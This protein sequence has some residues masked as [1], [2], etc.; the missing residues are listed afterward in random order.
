[1]EKSGGTITITRPS[2]RVTIDD[3]H[4]TRQQQVFK[5]EKYDRL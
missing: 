3:R 1:M 5:A 2:S 4:K